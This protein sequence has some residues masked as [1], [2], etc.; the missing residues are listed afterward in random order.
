MGIHQVKDN[1]RVVAI[2]FT[3]WNVV[4]KD[5]VYGIREWLFLILASPLPFSLGV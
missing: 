4:R 3:K 1:T 2:P 5:E